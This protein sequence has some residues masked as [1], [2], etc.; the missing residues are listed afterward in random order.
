MLFGE[1]VQSFQMSVSSPCSH[2]LVLVSSQRP[3][4][5]GEVEPCKEGDPYQCE[6]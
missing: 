5:S 4:A 1:E 3:L 6:A 2:W